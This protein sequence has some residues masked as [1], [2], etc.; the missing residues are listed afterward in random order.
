MSAPL[1]G[2]DPKLLF[3]AAVEVLCVNP[4]EAVIGGE[5][6]WDGTAPIIITFG[7]VVPTEC[8]HTHVEA[9]Y[10]NGEPWN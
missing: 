7:A 2:A 10:V 5:D 9:M 8:H 1:P 4:E 6:E 3:D